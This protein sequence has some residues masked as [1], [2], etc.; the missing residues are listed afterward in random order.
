MTI[1]RFP[2]LKH[3]PKRVTLLCNTW[4]CDAYINIM[5]EDDFAKAEAEAAKKDWLTWQKFHRC[6]RCRILED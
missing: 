2:P 1:L 5:D 3:A 6:P 4:G